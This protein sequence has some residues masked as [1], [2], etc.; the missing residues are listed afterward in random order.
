ML[1][2]YPLLVQ[3]LYTESSFSTQRGFSVNREVI[4]YTERLFSTQRVHSVHREVLQYTER[5]LR[6]VK[7][8]TKELNRT[9]KG[10]SVH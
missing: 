10:N 9:K 2:L 6:E 4:Q 7:Q 8:H 3:T 1:H 5:L